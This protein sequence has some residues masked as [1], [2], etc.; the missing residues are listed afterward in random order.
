MDDCFDD[1]MSLI[2]DPASGSTAEEVN[3]WTGFERALVHIEQQLQTPDVE[4]TLAILKFAK[5]F[6][7]AVSFE[8]DTGKRQ[9]SF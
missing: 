6:L 8:I 5:R 2:R 7:A 4:A 1:Q 9:T 3:F